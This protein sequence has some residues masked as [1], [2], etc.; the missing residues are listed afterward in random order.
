MANVLPSGA[1][2]SLDNKGY[3]FGPANNRQFVPWA[4]GSGAGSPPTPSTPPAP[5]P[6]PGAQWPTNAF[7]AAGD[8]AG[9]LQAL[10]QAR[11]AFLQQHQEILGTM[12]LPLR[13]AVLAASPELA[14]ASQYL[15][16][17]FQNPIPPG[18]EQEWAERLRTAQAARG[19]TG[20]SGP[21]QQEAKYLMGL[22]EERRQNLLPQLSQ[23]GTLMLNA[24]GLQPPDANLSA[25]G[26]MMTSQA[27]LAAQ[28][29]AGNKQSEFSQQM[30]DWYKTYLGK[31]GMGKTFTGI[32]GGS[33]TGGMN[34]DPTFGTGNNP[35]AAGSVAAP[36]SGW[37]SLL[38]ALK[39]AQ[40]G[41]GGGGLA[42]PT[43]GFAS[44][45][46]G[47]SWTG[48]DGST[49]YMR[50]DGTIVDTTPSQKGAV[51]GPDQ[52]TQDSAFRYFA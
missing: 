40:V 37:N 36:L 47:Q 3:W 21:A 10:Y 30:F 28:I 6:V 14:S 39:V 34:W 9:Y 49:Y 27:E 46:P 12:G 20:G 43:T 26:A 35:N 1:V 23:F 15:T 31:E 7:S 8:A 17:S 22:A 18:M 29:A 33:A 45:A 41:S 51:F 16:S 42:E 52:Y 44:H 32:A 38:S 48:A 24:T 25:L 4:A 11:P 19:F 13:N 50:S 2:A 5:S